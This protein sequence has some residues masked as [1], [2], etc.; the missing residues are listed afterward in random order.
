MFIEVRSFYCCVFCYIKLVTTSWTYSRFYYSLHHIKINLNLSMVCTLSLSLCMVSTCSCVKHQP[1]SSPQRWSSS[2][3]AV[4]TLL[5][6]IDSSCRQ[7]FIFTF[8][9]M[10]IILN[11]SSVHAWQTGHFQRNPILRLKRNLNKC[12]IKF[13]FHSTRAHRILSYH[14]SK[15]HEYIIMQ[16]LLFITRIRL[17]KLAPCPYFFSKSSNHPILNKFPDGI[18]LS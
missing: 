6:S 8:H 2:C 3:T 15:Y 17:F 13:L 10:M 18:F 5:S 7:A 4:Q 16:N 9:S 11:G 1:S 14:L 12:Q